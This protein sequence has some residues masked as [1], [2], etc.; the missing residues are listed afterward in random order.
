MSEM[1]ER[2]AQA[3]WDLDQKERKARTSIFIDTNATFFGKE[4]GGK[5]VPW[6]HITGPD[7]MPSVAEEWRIKAR[8]AIAAMREPTEAMIAAHARRSRE[9]IQGLSH[10]DAEAVQACRAMI[11]AALGEPK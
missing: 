1:V 7:V 3:L 8:A 4:W 10:L 9:S 5:A 2:V 6:S 11:D